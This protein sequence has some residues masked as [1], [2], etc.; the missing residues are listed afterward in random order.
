MRKDLRKKKRI[1][2]KE[3]INKTEIDLRKGKIKQKRKKKK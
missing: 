3:K 1:E 2:E